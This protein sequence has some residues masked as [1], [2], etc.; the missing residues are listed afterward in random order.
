MTEDIGDSCQNVL[1]R[2]GHS[3]L[4]ND[5]RCRLKPGRGQFAGGLVRDLLN[6]SVHL[7]LQV[8]QLTCNIVIRGYFIIP[9]S[10]SYFLFSRCV[11]VLMK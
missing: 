11:E 10:I 3:N 5:N 6:D 4:L 7:L 8:G 1:L 2:K 9:F